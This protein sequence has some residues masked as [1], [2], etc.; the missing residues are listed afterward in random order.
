MARQPWLNVHNF[1]IATIQGNS[2]LLAYVVE[3]DRQLSRASENRQ[4]VP[5]EQAG[6]TE[7]NETL[8]RFAIVLRRLRLPSGEEA[9]ILLGT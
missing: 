8:T 3:N 2:F 6:K 7:L 5:L 9:R 1:Y 4:A